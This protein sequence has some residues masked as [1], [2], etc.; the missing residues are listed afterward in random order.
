KALDLVLDAAGY[1]ELRAE[2]RRRRETNETHQLGIG[3]SVYVEITAGGGPANEWGAVDVTP[4]GKARVRTGVSP[5]G[6]G[7]ITSMSMIVAD[8]LG[9]DL[10]DVEVVWGDT[11]IVPKGV[12][13]MGSRSIQTGG[14]AVHRAAGLVVDK[15]RE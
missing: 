5:H 10:E 3:V 1:D 8:R 12:G 13:T 15:D 7:H 2:Q 6:Q 4:E 14:V 9:V 11:D